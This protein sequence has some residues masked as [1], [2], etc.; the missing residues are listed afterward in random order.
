MKKQHISILICAAAIIGAGVSMY[1]L[2][3]DMEK[4]GAP[5]KTAVLNES[6]TSPA[7]SATP[8]TATNTRRVGVPVPIDSED[9]KLSERIAEKRVVG[10][11]F[12]DLKFTAP[13]GEIV[14]HP[15]GEEPFVPGYQ[16]VARA[17]VG[18][19]THEITAN[20]IGAFP[21]ILTE[22]NAAIPVEFIYMDGVPGQAVYVSVEDGGLLEND[23]SAKMIRLSE[24]KRGEFKVRLNADEGRYRIALRSG[25]DKKTVEFWVGDQGPLAHPAPNTPPPVRASTASR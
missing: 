20:Q 4:P 11:A 3:R 15:Y 24:E 12:P 22:A 9:T 23:Q 13:V 17:V 5:A 16:V 1:Y 25:G 2:S 8:E 14:R 18:N 21:R 7:Q 10:T 19:E 6:P